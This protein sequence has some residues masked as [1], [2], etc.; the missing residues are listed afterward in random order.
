VAQSKIACS[1]LKKYLQLTLTHL[2]LAHPYCCLDA[3]TP[4]LYTQLKVLILKGVRPDVLC[5]RPHALLCHTPHLEVLHIN[6]CEHENINDENIA[7]FA[8][9]NIPVLMTRKPLITLPHLRVLHLTGFLASVVMLLLALPDP[10]HELLLEIEDREDDLDANLT[11]E[12]RQNARM[13]RYTTARASCYVRMSSLSALKHVTDH[14]VSITTSSLSNLFRLKTSAVSSFP[15]GNIKMLR[16]DTFCAPNW[17]IDDIIRSASELKV[18]TEAFELP[19]FT[20]I[21]RTSSA[22]IQHTSLHLSNLI[23]KKEAISL[24]PHLGH[25]SPGPSDR[26]VPHVTLEQILEERAWSNAPLDILKLI[27]EVGEREIPNDECIAFFTTRWVGA[28]GVKNIDF[29][30]WY[31]DDRS[32]VD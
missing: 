9:N 16:L 26:S 24:I 19:L 23:L 1:N 22:N 7:I 14:R 13:L 25:Y 10:T 30:R 18:T 3:V 28:G 31:H 15:Q 2:L 8:D 4:P 17:N 21:L 12:P 6:T 32:D 29:D 5:A 27:Y 11:D 20:H